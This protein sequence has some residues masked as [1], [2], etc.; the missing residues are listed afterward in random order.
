MAITITID[1]E[2]MVAWDEWMD[3]SW[4]HGCMDDAWTTLALS[5]T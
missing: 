4:I 1:A 2:W 3:R 5:P